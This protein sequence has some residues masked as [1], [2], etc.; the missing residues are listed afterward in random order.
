MES[1]IVNWSLYTYFLQYLLDKNKVKHQL[2]LQ[3][4]DI[5]RYNSFYN[6]AINYFHYLKMKAGII[7]QNDQPAVMIIPDTNEE[8]SSKPPEA[9]DNE[10]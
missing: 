3:E 5:L 1:H 7:K 6:D 2:N 9:D 4:Q 10:V 8:T